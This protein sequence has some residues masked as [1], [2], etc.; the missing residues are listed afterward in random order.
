MRK[1]NNNNNTFSLPIVARIL[2]KVRFSQLVKKSGVAKVYFVFNEL[3]EMLVSNCG[4]L[5]NKI[6]S[7]C[8]IKCLVCT[9]ILTIVVQTKNSIKSGRESRV[10]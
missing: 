8:S 1:L 3:G 4:S 6:L 7:N 10:F 5:R 2:R 9:F